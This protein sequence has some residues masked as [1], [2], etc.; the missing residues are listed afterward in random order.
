MF[1]R[2]NMCRCYESWFLR[3]GLADGS[4]AWWL[5]HLLT[6]PGAPAALVSQAQP[7]CNV[8]RLA[9]WPAGVA[10]CF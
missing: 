3:F 9:G 7:R 6:N 10:R 4:G 2:L 1:T 5:R 8:R